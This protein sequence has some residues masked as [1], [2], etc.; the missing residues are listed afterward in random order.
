MKKTL[1]TLAAFSLV[2]LAS[3]QAPISLDFNGLTIGNVGTDITGATPGQGGIFTLTNNG[4]PPTTS[5]NAGNDNFQIVAGDAAHGNVLQITGPNGD[6]GARFAFAG[7]LFDFW[8]GRTAGNNIVEVEWSFYTGAPT[9]SKNNFRGALYNDDGTKILGGLSFASDTKILSGLSYYNNAGTFANY[10]FTLE[11]GG[12]VLE[13]STWYTFGFSFNYNTGEIIVRTGDG[14]VNGT[15]AGAAMGV[16]PM[17]FD[18]VAS[19]GTNTA[20]PNAS[21]TTGLYDNLVIRTSST[22]TLLGTADYLTEASKLSVY[23]NPASDVVNISG[24]DVKSVSFADINGRTVKS[25]NVNSTQA[26][27]SI[28]DLST[29]VYMMTV[30]TADG[31]STTKK[32]LKK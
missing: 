9:T 1:L 6:K 16:D 8:D 4:A 25:V 7:D 15:I 10:L 31:A 32:L 24:A 23:P 22:D 27:I 11:T 5:T 19:S 21:A 29:G 26:T 3:A 28:S 12:L 17:E 30:E 13:A 20:G 14:T 18:I 2:T